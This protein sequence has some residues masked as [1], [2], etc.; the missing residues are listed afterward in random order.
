MTYKS[1]EFVYYR[2]N[3]R[4]LGRLRAILKNANDDQYR[5]KIQRVLDY[6][7]L[8]GIFKGKS[9]QERSVAGEVW[10]QD[11][12]FQIIIVS[13][14]LEKAT[15][16]I[17]Y[18][19]QHIPESILRIT[20]IV[21]KHQNRWH[22]RDAEFSY[23][24]PSDYITIRPPPSSMPT[25][26]LF[27]DLYY[28]DFGTYRNVYHSLGGIYLQF[29]NM[30][31]HQRK[32]I[33]NHFVLGFVPFG[34]NFDEF[35]LP[36]ISEMKKFEQGKTMKVQGQDA[37]V[38][39]G[40][41][42]VTSD[43]PQGNDMAGV[44]RHNANKGCR[45]CLVSREFLTKF[46]QDI[47]S[48]SR[49]HHITNEQFKEILQENVSSAKA[50]L[51]TKYGLRLKPSILDKLKRDR[52]L[53]NPQD[54]YHATAGKIGRLLGLTCELF[55]REGENDF[56]KTWKDFEKPKKWSRLPNPISHRDSFMMSD[57]L[58]L[59]MIM[60]YIL[61]RFLKVSL[62][63]YCNCIIFIIKYLYY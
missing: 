30:P 21:Y 22:I 48:I 28:D 59:A 10:L 49:Y 47:P 55:S 5:L 33:T 12:P 13:E 57:Y 54:V 62:L 63:H 4:Q 31:A 42:V 56:I 19:H 60:P 29:G 7:N 15:V 52:H 40:L 9:R 23:Q 45:T 2:Y 1:G 41:G 26:K 39:A 36:F 8:P 16:M 51:C 32:L 11:E 38:I 35:I 50:Q 6:D 61:Q 44:K 20:E 34:G 14:I 43:L 37:W 17:V 18:Q 53:Q 3:G 25:Y 58:R 24:H 27:I 46:D